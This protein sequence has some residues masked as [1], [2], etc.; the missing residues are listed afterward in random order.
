MPFEP[1]LQPVEILHIDTQGSQAFFKKLDVNPSEKCD[2]QTLLLNLFSECCQQFGGLVAPNWAGDGGHAFFPARVR[3]GDSVQ[4]AKAFISKQQVLT[5]QTATT[6]GRRMAPDEMRRQ[7]RIKAHFGLVY[8]GGT[9][10]KTD[11]GDPSE[12]DS[13]LKHERELA[14]FPGE[15]FIT[16][17][18]RKQLGGPEKELFEQFKAP[19]TYGSLLTAL[20]RMKSDPKYHARNLLEGGLAPKD[21]TDSEWRYLRSHILSQKLNVVARNSITTGLIQGTAAG[22]RI[23]VNLLT[24]LTLS[25]LYNYLRR[26]YPYYNFRAAIWHPVKT[27]SQIELEKTFAH[28]SS[29]TIRRR[30]NHTDT[31]YQVVRTF[32]TAVPAVTQCVN[33]SRLKNDW[34]DF[35]ASQA[36]P[37]RGLQSAIQMPIYRVKN[38]IGDHLEKDTLAVL[39]VDTDKP[40]FFLKEELD[41]WIEDFVGFLANLALAE[42]L[43]G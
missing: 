38:Q 36:D 34:T 39:S 43:R 11:S 27:G 9:D 12:F 25:A 14:P 32:R 35:D 3:S 7:F 20:Y 17:Q 15:L 33:E 4:A 29:A 16:D 1:G 21:I 10:A 13:F 22:E 18:L 41:L 6:L 28:P 19:E 30:V 37:A 31:Q 42:Q 24:N 2:C 8:L 40:D 5:Q 26:V 23:D